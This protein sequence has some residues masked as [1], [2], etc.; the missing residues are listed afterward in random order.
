MASVMTGPDSAM[1][2]RVMDHIRDPQ[3]GS[4]AALFRDLPTA[5]AVVRLPLDMYVLTTADLVRRAAAAPQVVIRD[6]E[7][8]PETVCEVP[9]F[10]EFFAS[11]LSFRDRPDHHRLRRVMSAHFTPR[12]VAALRPALEAVVAALVAQVAAQPGEV[13][14]VPALSNEIPARAMGLVLGFAED[15]WPWVSASGR[16]MLARIATSFPHLEVTD[17]PVTSAQFR[18]IR[19]RVEQLLDDD[20]PGYTLSATLARAVAAGELSRTEATDLMILLFMTGIDTVAASLTN[21]VLSLVG[22]PAARSA[23]LGGEVSTRDLI[24]ESLRITAPL[25]FGMRVTTAELD[26]GDG[27]L[28]PA[29]ATVILCN[30]SVNLDPARF[31]DPLSWRPGVRPLSQTFGHGTHRCLGALLAM[32][33]CE[34]ALEALRP[35]GVRVLDPA[36]ITWRSD[37]SFHTPTRLPV[38]VGAGWGPATTGTDGAEEV[39]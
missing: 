18:G 15:E 6:V 7:F 36:R 39:R 8:P 4:A 1:A 24:E 28:I 33:E 3:G 14:L 31:P 26:L 30:A 25:P 17:R 23:W 5:A 34:L 20:V 27:V 37:I 21:L 2:A 38:V 35:L 16:A 22:D 10:A 32:L 29:G 19:A 9:E 13:D 11:S 12:G